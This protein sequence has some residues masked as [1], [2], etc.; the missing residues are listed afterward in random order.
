MTKDRRKSGRKRI[1]YFMR[2]YDRD[3]D[4]FVGN[5]VDISD[6]GLMLIRER[7]IEP[8]TEIKMKIGLPRKKEGRDRITFDAHCLWCQRNIHTDFF[9][10]GFKL[11]NVSPENRETITRPVSAYLRRD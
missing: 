9:D 5:L 11:Q 1:A 10:T 4:K 3:T 6:R 8:N 2:V 7:P